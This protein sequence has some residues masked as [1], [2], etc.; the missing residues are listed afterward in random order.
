MSPE[1]VTGRELDAKSDQFT[2]AI[3]LAELL[4]A[5]PLFAG[6]REMDVL[7]KIRDADLSVLERHGHQIPAEL[8][9]VLRRALSRRRE[10]RF[11]T[12]AEY[13]NALEEVVRRGRLVAGPEPLVEWLQRVG[14]VKPAGR[15]G[16]HII[17]KMP[18]KSSS[19]DAPP[20]STGG[21]SPT[22]KA[23]G[24]QPIA[25]PVWKGVRSRHDPFLIRTSPRQ[26]TV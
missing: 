16:E 19:G 21:T 3:V 1:Q 17:E 4:T 6:P 22:A 9:A 26:R 24:A 5:R 13:V 25:Q 23:S 12:T 7:V 2:A 11:P 14:L 15:S 10:E 18:G 20:S 8:M